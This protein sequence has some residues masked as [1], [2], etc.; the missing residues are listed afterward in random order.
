ML[1]TTP[2]TEA[3]TSLR[4]RLSLARARSATAWSWAAWAEPWVAT[5]WSI[6]CLETTTPGVSAL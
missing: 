2:L 4:S 3:R 5:T 1:V 6:L